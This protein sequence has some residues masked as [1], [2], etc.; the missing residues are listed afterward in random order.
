MLGPQSLSR[1]G[2]S[3]QAEDSQ[4]LPGLE[5]KVECLFPRDG[6]NKFSW[7]DGRGWGEVRDSGG[8]GETWVS[9]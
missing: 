1:V 4:S 7:L 9:I 8:T 5:G 6:E 2:H 3:L